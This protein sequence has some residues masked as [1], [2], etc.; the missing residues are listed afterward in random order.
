MSSSVCRAIAQN[1]A[2]QFAVN[3]VKGLVDRF[4]AVD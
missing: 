1:E 4:A 3:G 2:E